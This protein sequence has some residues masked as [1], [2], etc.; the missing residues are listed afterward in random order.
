MSILQSI[1]LGIVQGLTEFL[2]VSSSGQLVIV[3]NLLGLADRIDERTLKSFDIF[4]HAGT[5]MALL[6]VFFAE[7][8]QIIFA[9]A[10]KIASFWGYQPSKELTKK[11]QGGL[12]L[13]GFLIIG[14]IP[15]ALLGLLFEDFFDQYLRKVWIVA[16]FLSISGVLFLLAERYGRKQ[17]QDNQIT[18]KKALIIGLFQSLAILPGFSR[19]GFSISGGL[20]QNLDRQQAARFSFLLAM[21]L[22]A[23]ASLISLLRLLAGDLDSS[24]SLGLIL[25]GFTSS[26]VVSY[27]TARFL[28]LIFRKLA[29]SFFSYF[30]FAQSLLLIGWQLWG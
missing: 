6:L 2:P 7:I 20:L 14:T 26:F 1:I 19:S 15:G 25:I 27:L 29:L 21:P 23:G 4:L 16:I 24:I 12:Q 9:L 22:I 17:R 5:L 28:L 10:F 30:L 13:L 18:K 3:H 8:K 11:S